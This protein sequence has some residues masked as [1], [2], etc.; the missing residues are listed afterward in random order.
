[1]GYVV[2]MTLAQPV[3]GSAQEREMARVERNGRHLC[4]W[5]LTEPEIIR[6]F[7]G[8]DFA[9]FE[10]EGEGPNMRILRRID[11]DAPGPRFLELD[12][13]DQGRGGR[14]GAVNFVHPHLMA[15]HV[16]DVDHELLGVF[17]V[18]LRHFVGHLLLLLGKRIA[19]R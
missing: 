11:G 13:V 4:F 8:R 9:W 1:M 2:K 17:A 5:K 16:S 10:A 15:G 12:S 14:K 7:E 19:R 6:Q 18:L 3:G